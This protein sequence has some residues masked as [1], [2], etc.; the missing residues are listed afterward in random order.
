VW[1]QWICGGD[2]LSGGQGW[3]GSVVLG[4]FHG[5]GYGLVGCGRHED[6]VVKELERDGDGGGGVADNCRSWWLGIATEI[7][8]RRR[9]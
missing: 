5:G 2:G 8:L 3:W 1:V 7:V 9:E 6:G 4:G